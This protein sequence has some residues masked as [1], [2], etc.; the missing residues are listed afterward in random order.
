LVKADGTVDAT[1]FQE[2][3]A[4]I[5]AGLVAKGTTGIKTLKI[6]LSAY[7]KYGVRC[8]SLRGMIPFP[9]SLLLLSLVVAM[10]MAYVAVGRWGR[11]RVPARVVLLSLVCALPFTTTGP[12]PAQ[13]ILGLVMGYLGLRMAALAQRPARPSWRTCLDLIHLEPLFE[14][15]ATP[16]S[17]PGWLVVAGL[18][19]IAACISLLWLGYV[20]RLWDQAG[21]LR[22]LD[23]LIVLVEVGVGAAGMHHVIAGVAARL[24]HHVSGFQDSPL[25][26]A[27][28]SDFWGKRWNRLVQRHLYEGFFRPVLRAGKP[29]RALFSAFAAS[30][31]L[32]LLVLGDGGPLPVLLPMVGQIMSFFLLHGA[33]VAI[34]RRLGWHHP[35]A[36]PRG[37]ALARARSLI[38]FV[39]L[40]PLFLDPF[41]RLA[42]VHGRS[43]APESATSSSRLVPLGP[44]FGSRGLRSSP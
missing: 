44:V 39:V 33:L 37:I 23:D 35:P 27:S 42:H 21:P 14:P 1:H 5:M 22:W 29:R 2:S 11:L 31:V 8:I 30:G 25:L 18:V 6:P 24:G 12:G 13:V 20:V 40:S 7:V 19:E 17:K 16:W 9:Y 15:R 36:C 10:G 32:H 3:G 43:P 34:E 26:S 41:A 38:L 4:N 28:L